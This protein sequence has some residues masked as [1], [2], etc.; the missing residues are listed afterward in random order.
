MAVARSEAYCDAER[1]DYYKAQRRKKHAKPLLGRLNHALWLTDLGQDMIPKM[2][3]SCSKVLILKD[4]SI[5]RSSR[6]VRISLEL[7]GHKPDCLALALR[8]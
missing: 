7:A 5:V 6:T 8:R 2:K 1:N 4:P 3:I